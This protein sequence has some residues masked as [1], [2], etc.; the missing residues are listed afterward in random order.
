MPGS[1]TLDPDVLVDS[2]VEDV[3]DGLR[4]ELHPLFGV[5]SYRLYT[6]LRTWSGTMPGEGTKIDVEVEL[7]PQPLIEVWG[8]YK[9]DLEP[10]GLDEMGVIRLREIS[11]TYTQAELIGPTLTCN[12]QWLM[13]L[14]EAHGQ[15]NSERVFIHDRPPYVD[16]EK[17]MGWVMWLRAA[18]A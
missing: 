13:K 1:A 2:L 14:K 8:G 7:T 3:I 12:Q 18:E 4:E 15:G 16:R 6:L 17:D 9:Y 11:L 5:R 10:C